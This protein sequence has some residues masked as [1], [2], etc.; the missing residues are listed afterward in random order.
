MTMGFWGMP[1]EPEY[2]LLLRVL[3]LL[4]R[5]LFDNSGGVYEV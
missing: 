2:V 5:S 3:E 4:L 1:V